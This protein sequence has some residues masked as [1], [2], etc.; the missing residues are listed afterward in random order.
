MPGSI[1]I[2][3]SDGFSLLDLL[4]LNNEFFSN[5]QFLGL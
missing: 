2:G 1:L 4:Q 5:F 3:F